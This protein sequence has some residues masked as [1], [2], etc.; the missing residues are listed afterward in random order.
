MAESHI[1]D[2]DQRRAVDIATAARELQTSE[3]FIRRR[4]ADGSLKA[5]RLKGSRLIRIYVTEL[6][7]FKQSLQPQESVTNE[8]L[9]ELLD[10][11]PPLSDE[12]RAKLAELLAPVRRSHSGRGDLSA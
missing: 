4:I 12:Q 10:K 5:F 9:K 1:H 2:V 8:Y 3:K 6:E 11:A 7:A